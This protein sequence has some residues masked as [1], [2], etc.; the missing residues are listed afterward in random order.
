MAQVVSHWPL[1][2]EA[3]IRAQ[4]VHMGCV[5]DREALRQVFLQIIQFFHVG[6]IPL[7]LQ[8]RDIVSLH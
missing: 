2:A 6:I 1:T 3:F 7:W 4:A 5:V 8:F